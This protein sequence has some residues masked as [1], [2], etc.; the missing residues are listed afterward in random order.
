M[1]GENLVL[2]SVM[3]RATANSTTGQLNLACASV[4]HLTPLDTVKPQ[5]CHH[6]RREK[7]VFRRALLYHRLWPSSMLS[8]SWTGQ[9]PCLQLS[10]LSCPK[11][12]SCKVQR[13]SLHVHVCVF[14]ETIFC[15]TISYAS[16]GLSP[17]FTVQTDSLT[18]T[19]FISS[20]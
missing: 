1:S 10:P 19:A 7:V 9:Q 2:D 11:Y 8:S 18:P 3:L 20:L 14:M 13:L 17:Q 5:R 12:R 15:M 6:E 4:S 16:V